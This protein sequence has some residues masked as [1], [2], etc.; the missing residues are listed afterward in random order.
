MT[1]CSTFR[2]E[3][4]PG[5]CCLVSEMLE[6]PKHFD[7]LHVLSSVLKMLGQR[8]AISSIM[9]CRQ[10][11][12]LDRNVFLKISSPKDSWIRCYKPCVYLKLWKMKEAWAVC[13]FGISLLRSLEHIGSKDLGCGRCYGHLTS[14][15]R[16]VVQIQGDLRKST[17]I[18]GYV[19]DKIWRKWD[20]ELPGHT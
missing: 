2:R 6:F 5:W 20:K 8:V 12:G 15:S 10:L 18:S 9:R 17:V 3:R 13:F 19:E 16:K 1:L 14:P 4:Q 11:D 7:G